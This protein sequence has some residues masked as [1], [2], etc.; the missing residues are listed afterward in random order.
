MISN[1]APTSV[2]RFGGG[3]RAWS[4]SWD[5]FEAVTTPGSTTISTNTISFHVMVVESQLISQVPVIVNAFA[6][7]GTNVVIHDQ[8]NIGKSF[9]IE[10]NSFHLTGGLTLPVGVNLASNTLLNVRN[11]T[12]D[13]IINILGSEFLGTDRPLSYS[14]YVNHGTNIAA[15][16]EIRT[17]YF[18]NT[19][20]LVA[21]GGVFTLDAVTANLVGNHLVESNSF[22]TNVFFTFGGGFVTNVFTN[23]TTL[24]AAP[25]IQGV[26]DVQIYARDLNLSNSIIKA[27]T[28]ILSVTNRLSDGGPGASNEWSV[29]SGVQMKRRPSTSDLMGTH[30]R[31]TVAVLGESEHVW[32]AT[33]L[34][35][36]TAGFS[37]NL[38]LGKLTL[39]GGLGSI[40]QFSGVGANNALY[41]D[42]IELLNNAT[43]FT[44]VLGVATNL[45]IYF[46]NA[47]VPV[48][49]LNG[50]AGGRFRWVSDFTGPLSSTNITYSNGNTY[51]FNVALVRSQD[52]DSDGDGI[53]NADDPEPI[54][55]SGSFVVSVALVRDQQELNA[56]LSWRALAYSSNFP[57]RSLNL[58]VMDFDLPNERSLTIIDTLLLATLKLSAET[59]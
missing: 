22:V 38:A 36:S 53:V 41:V 31:S 7:R 18:A 46:A 15:S 4:A 1:L 50:T 39:D 5:N 43:N 24:Q 17:R 21:N 40:F 11:F 34:G 33:N 29:T 2:R 16:H 47:N 58:S 28:L 8:L 27:G 12:N 3:L 19:A 9:L 32:A 49:K 35:V 20:D 55:V 44:S 37:N 30:L 6:G 56:L 26:S 13:G 14:N 45:T 42:Y 48:N 59:L 52:L 10:G 57:P 54:L 51:T 23:T 25:R